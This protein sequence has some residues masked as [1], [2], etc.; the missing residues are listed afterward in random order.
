MSPTAVTPTAQ[1]RQNSYQQSAISLLGWST[2][3]AAVDR[4]SLIAL[5]WE[6]KSDTCPLPDR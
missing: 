2:L 6:G 5:S 1:A 3:A 4:G